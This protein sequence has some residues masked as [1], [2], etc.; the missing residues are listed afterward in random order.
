MSDRVLWATFTGLDA[1]GAEV[2]FD[3]ATK[4]VAKPAGGFIEGRI[5]RAGV[6]KR[7]MWS[8][9]ALGGAMQVGTLTLVLDNSDGALDSLVDYSFD[10]QKVLFYFGTIGS[11]GEFVNEYPVDFTAEQPLL[12]ETEVTFLLRDWRHLLDKPLLTTK[13]AGT[14]SGSPLAGIEGTANDLKGKPKPMLLGRA[15]NVTP[16]LV[17]TDRLIYQVDGYDG[18]TTGYSIT[19]YDKRSALTKGADYISQAQMEST[20]PAAG[21]FRVHPATGCF[22]L[23]TAPVG[24]VTA[25]VVNP[26]KDPLNG[27][28]VPPYEPTATLNL[29]HVARRIAWFGL[30]TSSY[31]VG[32]TDRYF[33]ADGNGGVYFTEELSVLTALEIALAGAGGCMLFGTHVGVPTIG[34][35]A[36]VGGYGVFFAQLYEPSSPSFTPKMGPLDLSETDIEGDI[37]QLVPAG[38]ERGLPVWRINLSCARNHTV[39]GEADLAGVALAD[40]LY[41]KQAYRTVNAEDAAVKVQWPDATEMSLLTPLNTVSQGQT[42]ADRLLSLF[43]SRRS[44]YRVTAKGEAMRRAA[45]AVGGSI[46]WFG[47]SFQVNLTLPR[48]ELAAGKTFVVI[49]V[50]EDFD[51]DLFYLT[52]WG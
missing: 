16:V 9:V 26:P 10:G 5:K 39:M 20:A 6:M 7:T 3:F 24:Q 36:G 33:S 14:N 46:V 13:Y 48:F 31:G 8:D 21:Q 42:E 47:P 49:A 50:E 18:L 40:A 32:S 23:G 29:F 35:G 38:S 22:R 12:S 34:P 37:Q 25:D 44:M 15:W 28:S 51:A 30:D 1:A 19:V 17:N 52:L 11:N 41:C 2:G 4:G 43:A 27:A 45:Q